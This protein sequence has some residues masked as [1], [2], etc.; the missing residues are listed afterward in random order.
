M[1]LQN[2]YDVAIIGG[3]L[4]GLACSIL[5][6]KAGCSVVVFEKDKYPFHKVCGEY[7][8]MESWDFL[9]GL[10]LSLQQL[11]LPIIT[12]L[13]V[14]STNGASFITKLPLGGFGISRYLFD[15][16]LFGLAK[17]SG[18]TVL[19]QTKVE[20][21]VFEEGFTIS[22][23]TKQKFEQ[24]TTRSVVCCGAY[25]KRSNLDVKWRRKFLQQNNRYSQNYVGVKYHIKS[26]WDESIIALHNFANGYCGISKI[27]EDKFCLCYLTI[28]SNLKKNR[29][30][31]NQ[32]EENI[33]YRNPHL[34][35]IFTTS[36]FMGDFPVTISQ[37]SFYQKTQVENY[38]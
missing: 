16:L 9:Q 6:A 24:H 15:N 34:K 8:S 12:K 25:G 1:Q 23:S 28:A 20:D 27:E 3:G 5:L 32:M 2:R 31:I 37:I 7:V 29:N 19:E 14:T 35:K 38:I 11:Q 10:G 30:N 17:Q 21:V 26:D 13:Q 18:V 22:F 36:N 4:A 33:L